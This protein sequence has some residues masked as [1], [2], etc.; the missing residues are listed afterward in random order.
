MGV[1]KWTDFQIPFILW[2]K[3]TD[4]L[5]YSSFLDA[6]TL[7][8]AWRPCQ[9]CIEAIT[10]YGVTGLLESAFRP[11]IILN[12][13]W[14]WLTSLVNDYPSKAGKGLA[15]WNLQDPGSVF[16]GNQ[17]TV[18]WNGLP[19]VRNEELTRKCVIWGSF[20]YPWN[21]SQGISGVLTLGVKAVVNKV[22]ILNALSWE[23]RKRKQV[24]I[25]GILDDSFSLE[26]AGM[27]PWG[28]NVR[29]AGSPSNGLSPSAV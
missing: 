14:L 2:A 8:L 15:T 18:S 19:S 12:Q 28:W 9:D 27:K 3:K 29:V 1:L 6:S 17:G 26:K 20:P 24:V 23:L 5:S 21:G 4:P 22:E 11:H 7:L 13:A 25:V 16:E 10:L